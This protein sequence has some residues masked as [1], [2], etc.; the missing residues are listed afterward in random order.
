MLVVERGKED[1]TQTTQR[2][3]LPSYPSCLESYKLLQHFGSTTNRSGY[4]AWVTTSL[5]SYANGS[6]RVGTSQSS[7]WEA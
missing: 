4:V 5:Y 6:R 2:P 3:W 1:A 7:E